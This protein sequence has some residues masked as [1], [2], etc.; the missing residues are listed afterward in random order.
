M[1]GINLLTGNR[2][3]MP[4]PEITVAQH[5]ALM[6]LLD[7]KTYS[8]HITWNGREYFRDGGLWVISWRDRELESGDR[9]DRGDLQIYGRIREKAA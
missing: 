2:D 1:T 3:R 9:I 4:V 6:V 8:E 5:D 7:G